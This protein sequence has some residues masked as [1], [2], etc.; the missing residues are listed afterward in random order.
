MGLWKRFPGFS[1]FFPCQKKSG[2]WGVFSKPIS[3]PLQVFSWA[4][5]FLVPEQAKAVLETVLILDTL[6][7]A[8]YDEL[9][10]PKQWS[11]S[12]YTTLLGKRS[13]DLRPHLPT[14]CPFST[15]L[16]HLSKQNRWFHGNCGS[17]LILGQ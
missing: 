13:D 15:F 4:F 8:R 12:P 16:Q 10:S 11:H 7:L 3:L 9:T 6:C 1:V 17:I 5:Y 14:P 2:N